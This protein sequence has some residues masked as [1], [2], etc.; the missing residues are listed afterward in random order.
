MANAHF[1]QIKQCSQDLLTHLS[2]LTFAHGS[3][4]DNMA[5]ELTAAAVFHENVNLIVPA[6]HLV[7]LGDILV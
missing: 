2:C 1:L 6:D 5:E 7:D 3:I 4:V